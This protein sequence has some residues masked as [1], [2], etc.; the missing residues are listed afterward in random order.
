ML[1]CVQQIPGG[2]SVVHQKGPHDLRIERE[3][4]GLGLAPTEGRDGGANALQRQLLEG[5]VPVQQQ[6]EEAAQGVQRES[7]KL[8]ATPLLVLQSIQ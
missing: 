4:E 8:I 1:D 7:V 5:E 2:A 3:V 6:E